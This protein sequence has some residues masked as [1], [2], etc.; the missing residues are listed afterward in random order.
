MVDIILSEKLWLGVFKYLW[1]LFLI[2]LLKVKVKI[3]ILNELE[4]SSVIVIGFNLI[5]FEYDFN[6]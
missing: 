6:S 3:C 2:F 1:N 4:L 5:Y